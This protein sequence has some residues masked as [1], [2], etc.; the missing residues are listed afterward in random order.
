MSSENPDT[1]T[2]IL[3]SAWKLLESGS[4]SEVRMS[5]IAREAGI[6]RQALYLHFPKRADLLVAA[7]RYVDEV[8]DVQARLEPSRSAASGIERLDAFIDAWGNYIPLIYG[9]AKA[10]ISMQDEDEAAR[11][12]WSDRLQAVRE[13]FEA[14]VAALERDGALPPDCSPKQ[15]ADLLWTMVSVENWEHL[16]IDCAWPQEDFVAA[17]KSLARRA[18]VIEGGR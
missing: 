15:A 18:L 4:G 2:R 17:M 3:E 8:N 1:R 7:T 11:L 12:A 14:A 13:G 5:D 10:L 6:S 16:V 9:I